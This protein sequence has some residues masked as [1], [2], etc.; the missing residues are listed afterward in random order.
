MSVFRDGLNR[1]LLND[2][3]DRESSTPSHSNKKNHYIFISFLFRTG[4][5]SIIF[6]FILTDIN[7]FLVLNVTCKH[8]LP[9]ID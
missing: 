6:K 8:Y 2:A 9:S 3:A 1:V 7:H 5:T 4:K